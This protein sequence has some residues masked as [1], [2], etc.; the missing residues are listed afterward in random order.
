MWSLQVIDKMQHFKRLLLLYISGNE[1]EVLWLVNLITDHKPA[2]GINNGLCYYALSIPG[3]DTYGLIST[4]RDKSNYGKVSNLWECNFIHHL[5]P[6]LSNN[7]N[8]NTSW[9]FKKM[10]KHTAIILLLGC[11][12][13][14]EP[15]L[16]LIYAVEVFD[17]QGGV[18]LDHAK[19]KLHKSVY[20]SSSLKEEGMDSS[21]KYQSDFLSPPPPFLKETKHV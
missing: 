2:W 14:T 4:L 21:R 3:R 6:C 5:K 1:S 20:L 9:D 10:F 18:T 13:Q 15:V 7:P 19:C 17:P 12:D 8:K 11:R 16:Y